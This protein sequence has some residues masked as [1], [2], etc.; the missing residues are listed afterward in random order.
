LRYIKIFGS[1]SDRRRCRKKPQITLAPCLTYLET[2]LNCGFRWMNR[3]GTISNSHQ[4]KKKEHFLREGL[5]L[6]VL[7]AQRGEITKDFNFENFFCG[8]LASFS[9]QQPS[10]F[11]IVAME[12]LELY[13]IGRDDLYR[14]FDQ[15]SDIQKLGRTWMEMMFIRKENREAS[16]LLDTAEQRYADCWYNF[17]RSNNGYH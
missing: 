13:T 5:C 17:R 16:F 15:Y 3:H 6:L 12:D 10:R 7:P 2:L 8:S 1:R 14:L 11:N 9:M 4:L